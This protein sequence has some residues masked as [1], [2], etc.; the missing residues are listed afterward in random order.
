MTNTKELLTMLDGKDLEEG[1]SILEENCFDCNG[2]DCKQLSKNRFL[3][4]YNFINSNGD[5][6]RYSEYCSTDVHPYADEPDYIPDEAEWSD[7][8]GYAVEAYINIDIN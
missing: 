4:V 3:W 8:T 6:I 1:K 5:E 7:K 2:V